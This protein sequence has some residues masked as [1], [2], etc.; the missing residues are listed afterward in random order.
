MPGVFGFYYKNYK[1]NKQNILT[2]MQMKLSHQESYRAD[3][4][5]MPGLGFGKIDVNEKT[6]RKIYIDRQSNI[7]VCLYG[8][9]YAIHDI[10]RDL[11]LILDRS[12]PEKL[13]CKIYQIYGE[14]TG[15]K[16]NGDFNFSIYDPG[17]EKLLIC[18]D[19]FGFRHLYIYEDDNIVMFSPEIKA[20]DVY[21]RFDK[22]LDEQGIS[23]YFNF[24]YHMGDRTNFRK[25]KVLAPASCFISEK[26]KSHKKQYWYP[27][28]SQTRSLK[29]LSEAVDTGYFLFCQ[30]V[31]RRISNSRNILVTLTGGLDSRLI[32]SVALQKRECRITT[33]TFG[34]RRCLEYNIA[35]K[36]C[37]RLDVD[38]PHLI[39]IKPEWLYEYAEDL[40]RYNE[41]GHSNLFLT[42]QYGF[43]HRM[44]TNFDCLLNGIFGG[45]LSFG[46][47]YFKDIALKAQFSDQERSKRL[48][49]G[50]DGDRYDLF[51]RKCA[52]PR[53]ND[54]IDAYREKTINEQWDRTES[55][56]D[57]FHFRWDNFFLHNRIR[58]GMNAID[59]NRFFYNDQ[60]PFAS[61]ELYDYYLTLSADLLLKHKLYKEIYKSKLR[62]MATVPWSSTGV[63]LFEKPSRLRNVY[64]HFKN[65]IRWY[66]KKFSRG[67]IEFCNKDIIENTSLSYRKNKQLR[68]WINSILLS[69]RCLDRGYLRKDGI[70]HLL[71]WEKYG[72]SAFPEISKMIVFEMWARKF[73]D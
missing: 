37:N 70:Q 23:D 36:V 13:L 41:C 28:Y 69:D 35:R 30:S 72:G 4:F 12:Y 63:N 47:P 34:T 14:K 16:L 31:D 62:H 58:R 48:I 54:I 20:F 66:S 3:L 33:A 56:S 68:K 59:Q 15:E 65:K 10:D 52:T 25:V 2:L 29:D 49:H 17:N 40:I 39:S 9:I 60:F 26:R 73:L 11:N 45:H 19:R 8:E 42:T 5:K 44:G 43:A 21:H 18:N 53:L 67:R 1:K 27:K 51:L 55:A 32:L 71:N 22:T 64:N 38:E 7:A 50:L 46:S 24:F 61:Y 6:H 57:Q